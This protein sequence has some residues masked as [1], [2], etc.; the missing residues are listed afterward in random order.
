MAEKAQVV[1]DSIISA[2][3]GHAGRRK[4]RSNVRADGKS[5]ARRL[6]CASPN[7]LRQAG[8]SAV[9]RD[10]QMHQCSEWDIRVHLDAGS[11]VPAGAEEVDFFTAIGNYL[12]L[13]ID[14]PPKKPY[15]IFSR[16]HSQTMCPR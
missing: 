9:P 12:W 13:A 11:L 6:L 4:R 1:A 14:V 10:L 7:Y 5:P 8:V 15:G 2:A 3:G 16:S